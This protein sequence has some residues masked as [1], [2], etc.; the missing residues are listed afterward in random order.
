MRGAG[1][2][3][4]HGPVTWSEPN[5]V[6]AYQWSLAKQ[7]TLVSG[8]TVETSLTYLDGVSA[9]PPGTPYHVRAADLTYAAEIWRVGEDT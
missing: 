1:A 8:D 4:Q 5:E 9:L 2:T 3:L 6:G 7:T